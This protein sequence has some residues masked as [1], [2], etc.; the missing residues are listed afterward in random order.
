MFVVENDGAEPQTAEIGVAM[1]EETVDWQAQKGFEGIQL[2]SVKR[3][4]G[5][6][7]NLK[8]QKTGTLTMMCMNWAKTAASSD[9]GLT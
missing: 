5:F 7:S 4:V 3:E 2:I 9:A 8:S 1:P 6:S